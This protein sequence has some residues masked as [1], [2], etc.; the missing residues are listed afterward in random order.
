MEAFQ[1]TVI[2]KVPT[3]NLGL[4]ISLPYMFCPPSPITIG[5]GLSGVLYSIVHW[6]ESPGPQLQRYW[7]N[8]RHWELFQTA[9]WSKVI[10]LYYGASPTVAN[11]TTTPIHNTNTSILAV[12]PGSSLHVWM[13]WLL[14]THTDSVHIGAVQQCMCL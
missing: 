14:F 4:Q 5:V 2:Y 10:N 1:N 3:Y 11:N 8:P 7:F 6:F 12:I 9:W 13:L